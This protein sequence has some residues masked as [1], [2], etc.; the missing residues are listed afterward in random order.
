MHYHIVDYFEA[1]IF[2]GEAEFKFIGI[3][4][5]KTAIFKE[6]RIVMHVII[7]KNVT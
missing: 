4:F 3:K 6:V 7:I 2:S 1:E 5:L